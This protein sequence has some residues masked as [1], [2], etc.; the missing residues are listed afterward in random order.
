MKDWR[1]QDWVALVLVLT[2]AVVLLGGIVISYLV[3]IAHGPGT[4]SDEK[5]LL[6]WE[7]M[8][9]MIIAALAGYIAGRTEGYKG[10]D[11]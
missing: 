4:T 10:E 8:V 6:F 11:K 1:P 7:N 5:E 3:A 2:L 9:G